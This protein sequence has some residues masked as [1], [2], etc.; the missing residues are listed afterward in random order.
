MNPVFGEFFG[1]ASGVCTTLAFLPQA[2]KSIM[3]RNVSGL[4]LYMYVINC[5]GLVLWILYGVYLHSVQMMLFN[6]ITLIFN[7]VILYMIITARKKK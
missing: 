6:S 5:I 1:Y 4:S 3:T 7:L 2:I